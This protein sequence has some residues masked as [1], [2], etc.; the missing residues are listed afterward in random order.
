MY[1]YI[2]K[3]NKKHCFR[4]VLGNL[5]LNNMTTVDCVLQL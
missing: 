1:T 4:A 2:K 3:T 5:D